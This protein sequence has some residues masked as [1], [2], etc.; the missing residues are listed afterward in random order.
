MLAKKFQ[1]AVVACGL[2]VTG[3]LLGHI[4]EI[5]F[6]K[7]S[8]IYSCKFLIILLEGS[9]HISGN[10]ERKLLERFFITITSC[11]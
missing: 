2:F 11:V 3:Y 6:A 8:T 7:M 4:V 9:Y 1:I 5:W 10:F